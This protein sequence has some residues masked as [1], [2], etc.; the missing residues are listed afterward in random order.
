VE[1][2]HVQLADEGGVIAV[3]EELWDQCAGK[4]VLVQNDERAA[5]VRPSDQICVAAI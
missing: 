2:V 1:T 3:L 5:V 4:L